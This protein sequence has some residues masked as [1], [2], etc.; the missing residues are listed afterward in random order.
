MMAR[1]RQTIVSLDDTPYYHGCS[2][3]V[4]NAFLCGIDVSTGAHY[5]YRRAWVNS[6]LLELASLFC[7]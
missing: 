1:P 4:R 5:E 6:R 2:H 7:D 3:V